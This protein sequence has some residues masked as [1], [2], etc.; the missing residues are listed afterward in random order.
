[1]MTVHSSGYMPPRQPNTY[2]QIG[3]WRG[4]H[5][6]AG[7]APAGPIPAA[8]GDFKYLHVVV[9]SPLYEQANLASPK[10]DRLAE[11]GGKYLLLAHAFEKYQDGKPTKVGDWDR[12]WWLLGN[13]AKEPLGWFCA[14]VPFRV[15]P[16]EFDKPAVIFASYGIPLK[17]GEWPMDAKAAN[18]VYRATD[19]DI[20]AINAFVMGHPGM[21]NPLPDAK[22][23]PAATDESKDEPKDERK[24]DE[25][26]DDRNVGSGAGKAAGG[27]LLLG[28]AVAALLLSK[29]GAK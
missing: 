3:Y 18:D 6:L 22:Q 13:E 16:G 2:G 9:D 23:I 26:K 25:R 19:K 10:V 5:A 21:Y 12:A 8:L 29:G 27:G 17:E 20:D 15:A 7:I 1:M 28:L 14:N 4:S 24:D 11:Q